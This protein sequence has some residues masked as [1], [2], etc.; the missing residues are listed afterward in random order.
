MT[1]KVKRFDRLLDLAQ[2]KSSER[3]RELLREVTDLF[4]DDETQSFGSTGKH[5]DDILSTITKEMDTELR[6]EIATRFARTSTA[7]PGLIRQL[8][9]DDIEVSDPVLRHSPVLSDV[10][11]T[12]IVADRGQ[13]HMRAIS[14]RTRLSEEVTGAIVAKGDTNTLIALTKNSGAS[15]SRDSMETLVSKSEKQNALQAPLVNHK[16]LPPDLLNEMYFFVEDRLRERI[17]ER[18]AKIPE[19]ELD[20]AFAQA[21]NQICDKDQKPADFDEA[22]AFVDAKK[23][24]KTLTPALLAELA[25]RNHMTRYYLAFAELT[26]LDYD[27]A[28]RVWTPGKGEAAAIVCKAT[29]FPRDLYA[30]LTVLMSKSESTGLSA[31]S[32]ISDA[33]DSIP[34]STAERTLRFWQ[35]RKSTQDAKAA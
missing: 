35:M 29:N 1:E 10:D 30:T 33:Y 17:M 18:N 28:M 26:G 24:R 8:A 25:R 27:T 5:F 14:A 32:A 34:K 19:A 11:L 15:F 16:D 9:H 20:R 7:P 22:R 4:F 31:I 2:E 21:R 23:L 6:K 12:N 3:R 13:I